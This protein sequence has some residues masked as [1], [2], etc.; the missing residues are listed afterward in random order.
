MKEDFNRLRLKYHGNPT[1]LD[2]ILQRECRYKTSSKLSRTLENAKFRF[3]SLSVAEMATSDDIADVHTSLILQGGSILDMTCGLGIDAFHMA[4]IAS[5]VTSIEIDHTTAV[6]AK[7]N[8]NMLRLDNVEIIES[9]SVEWLQ[10][11]D[12]YFNTIFIDPAR[13]DSRGRHYA[14]SDCSPNIIPILPLLL[15]RC[16]RLLIKASPMA[17]IKKA[18]SELGRTCDIAVIGTTKECKEIVFIIDNNA[19]TRAKARNI[20]C[21]TI[22]QPNFRFTPEEESSA[23]PRYAN[24]PLA[25]NIL[26]E[27]FPSVMKGGGMKLITERF[28]IAKLHPNTNLYLSDKPVDDF[29]GE[30]FEII[31]VMPFN[32][33]VVKKFNEI[34]PQ[35]NVSTRNFPLSSPELAAKLRIKE[36][37]DQMVFGT[38]TKDN[39]KILIVSS[40]G[41]ICAK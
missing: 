39:Q 9:D 10:S 11:H 3:P 19:E 23:I 35:I 13:R 37:G 14:F 4:S 20:E 32:K 31:E 7:H 28:D 36:G 17:D 5:H 26:F 27:P 21:I 40:M 6:T 29:P 1:M 18:V 15:S 30:Y 2:E 12:L 16:D 25:G 33:K 34:Y 8:V 22:G 38:T 41:C 24:L